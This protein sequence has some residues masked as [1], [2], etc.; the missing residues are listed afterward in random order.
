LRRATRL[1]EFG[2]TT[3]FVAHDLYDAAREDPALLDVAGR[4]ESE[5]EVEQLAF[6][7]FE[8]H[9]QP[10][11]RSSWPGRPDHPL[12]LSFIR[13]RPPGAKGWQTPDWPGG[14]LPPL[15][16]EPRRRRR[17]G[18][19]SNPLLIARV[20]KAE[21][22]LQER[23]RVTRPGE[24]G[25]GALSY[26]AIAAQSGLNRDRVTQIDKLME[27]GW[28]LRDSGETVKCPSCGQ[29]VSAETLDLIELARQSEW[30]HRRR[31]V[32]EHSWRFRNLGGGCYPR[33]VAEAYGGD[34]ERALADSDEDV[35]A[36][37]AS[38]EQAQGFEPVNWS[39][40]GAQFRAS[41][42]RDDDLSF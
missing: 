17:I 22:R 5:E 30:Y 42:E 20:E 4:C 11:K 15:D 23:R 39:A 36:T 27:M 13:P 34:I 25:H 24:R 38:W 41:A 1:A 18:R 9:P 3:K 31:V 26:E 14:R 12:R 19:P 8:E 6:E 10:T 33:T 35:A 2:L 28:P 32:T 7:W 40:L 16:D 37:V 29:Q 21:A